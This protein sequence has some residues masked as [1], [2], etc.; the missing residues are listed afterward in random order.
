M[1]TSRK[2]L[3]KDHK[4]REVK[5][6]KTKKIAMPKRRQYAHMNA[7]MLQ[8]KMS[9]SYRYEMRKKDAAKRAAALKAKQ[10]A[11]ADSKST[12]PQLKAK[13]FKGKKGGK[14]P[15]K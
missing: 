5:Q 2:R 14:K 12:K 1:D 9:E 11:A 4:G 6:K 10:K 8:E 3:K 7:T 13:K 15:K